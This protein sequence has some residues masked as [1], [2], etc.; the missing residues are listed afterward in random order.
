MDFTNARQDIEVGRDAAPELQDQSTAMPWNIVASARGSRFGSS[1]GQGRGPLSAGPPTS[2]M[3]QSTVYGAELNFPSRQVSRIT[4]ASPQVGKETLG[5]LARLSSLELRERAED[6]GLLSELIHGGSEALEDFEFPGPPAAEPQLATDEPPTRQGLDQD[7]TN[8]LQYILTNVE[9]A[10]Q[11]DPTE[12]ETMIQSVKFEVLLPPMRH[13]KVVAAQAFHH[14]LL[15][16]TRNVIAV[17]Q[18]TPF[19]DIWMTPVVPT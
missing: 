15:L 4:S 5:G 13:S 19:G 16:A 8:F 18:A 9:Q 10:Q 6:T 17:E 14:T 12:E 2:A 7:S 1:I 11:Q 3:R